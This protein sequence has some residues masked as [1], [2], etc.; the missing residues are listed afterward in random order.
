[1]MLQRHGYDGTIGL[2]AHA[3]GIIEPILPL[4]YP[5]N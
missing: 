3:Q 4:E 2:G 1:M 5:K